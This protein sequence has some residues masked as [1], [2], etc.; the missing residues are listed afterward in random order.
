MNDDSYKALYAAIYKQAVRDDCA[1]VKR[2]LRD[3]LA[4]QGIS[5]RKVHEYIKT[6][7]DLIKKK[8]AK[9]VLKEAEHFG[10]L[11]TWKINKENI[12]KLVNDLVD[13]FGR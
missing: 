9:G 13:S 11:E 1:E 5:K 10:T 6:N 12:Y 3:R 4:V 7:N 2:Q 8:V